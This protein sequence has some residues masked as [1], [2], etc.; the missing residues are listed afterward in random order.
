[1]D[2]SSR[3]STIFHRK[4]LPHT[5]KVVTSCAVGGSL[6]AKRSGNHEKTQTTIVGRRGF[7]VSFSWLLY[8][9]QRF[10]VRTKAVPPARYSSLNPKGI[11]G[12]KK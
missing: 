11:W 1:M 8:A 6:E 5:P 7:A 10:K 3:G 4:F 2:S 9:A 12:I